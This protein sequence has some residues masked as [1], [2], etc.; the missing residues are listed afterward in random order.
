M[1]QHIADFEIKLEVQYNNKGDIIKVTDESDNI[2]TLDRKILGFV[3]L[4]ADNLMVPGE[5]GGWVRYT[6]ENDE[7]QMIVDCTD[8]SA[9]R[10]LLYFRFDH[11]DVRR[12]QL[13][14]QYC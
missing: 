3:A 1:R 14:K 9:T 7:L 11:P 8:V 10:R 5:Q 12:R 6:K 2:D 4:G 13:R